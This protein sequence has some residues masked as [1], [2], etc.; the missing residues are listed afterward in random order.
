M[1]MIPPMKYLDLPVGVTTTGN[2]LWLAPDGIA[3]WSMSVKTGSLTGAFRF[4]RSDDPR[5]RP[6]SSPVDRAAA[7]WA[8]FT[9]EVASQ[10]TNPAAGAALFNVVVPNF[11]SAFLRMDYVH[12]SGTGPVEAFFSGHGDG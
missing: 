5:A 9:S 8:E 7:V 1:G 3:G 10:I 6:D 11:R 2:A 12:T 4:Y